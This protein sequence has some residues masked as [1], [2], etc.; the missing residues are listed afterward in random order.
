MYDYDEK[1]RKRGKQLVYKILEDG[2]EFIEVNQ[3][4]QGPN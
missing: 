3:I 4:Y 1:L 2:R